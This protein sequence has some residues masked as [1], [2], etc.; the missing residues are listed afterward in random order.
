MR[1]RGKLILENEK[2]AEMSISLIFKFNKQLFSFMFGHLEMKSYLIL[3]IF[4]VI[5]IFM[6]NL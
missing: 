1:R 6:L 2:V 4:L 3:C 5:Y